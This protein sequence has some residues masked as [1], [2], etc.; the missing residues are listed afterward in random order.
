M[1]ATHPVEGRH[2][3]DVLLNFNKTLN[4]ELS[5]ALKVIT[6]YSLSSLSNGH[7]LPIGHLA[8]PLAHLAPLQE[9]PTLLAGPSRLPAAGYCNRLDTNRFPVTD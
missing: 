3:F 9:Q 5:N 2:A 7:L 1:N 6:I 8:A 4:E